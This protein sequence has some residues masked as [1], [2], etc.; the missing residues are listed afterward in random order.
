MFNQIFKYEKLFPP[1]KCCCCWL[2][3][4]DC[5]LRGHYQEVCTN[6]ANTK[7]VWL[8]TCDFPQGSS[9]IPQC[10]INSVPKF[11]CEKLS[12]K[13]SYFIQSCSFIAYFIPILSLKKGPPS[14]GLTTLIKI[15]FRLFWHI[16]VIEV[17]KFL[18]HPFVNPGV[19]FSSFA[20][21]TFHTW[22]LSPSFGK[23]ELF[24]KNWL[25]FHLIARNVH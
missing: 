10:L 14:I 6:R 13:K 8:K 18:L 3:E 16:G 5:R 23:V 9:S 22:S 21:H 1:S 20:N 17:S 15:W 4:E 12:S 25:L 19:E 11:F 2:Q 24:K 7:T